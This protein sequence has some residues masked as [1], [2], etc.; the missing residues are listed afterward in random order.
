LQAINLEAPSRPAAATRRSSGVKSAPPKA[1]FKAPPKKRPA[2]V[3]EPLSA[4][5]PADGALEGPI[6]D[7]STLED[8]ATKI[9]RAY[10]GWSSAAGLVPIPWL[11]FAVIVGVQVKMVEELAKL[12][13]KPFDNRTVRPMVVAL[14]SVSG[15]CLLAGPVAQLLKAV[16][17]V[18]PVAG[19][20]TLPAFATASCWA[21]GQIFIRHFESG[22]SIHDFSPAAA[23]GV[24]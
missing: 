12:Y 20:L 22:G 19:L 6:L 16:P 11:D 15:G 13:D 18:G 7:A 23:M 17:V 3:A 9:V 21:T 1:S 10:L 4:L 8:R 2:V 14:L 5:L 24:A